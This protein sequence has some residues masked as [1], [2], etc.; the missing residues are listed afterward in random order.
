MG[1]NDAIPWQ[2]TEEKHSHRL[3]RPLPRDKRR[4]SASAKKEE[5]ARLRAVPVTVVPGLG[6]HAHL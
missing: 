6:C 2:C 3:V 4:G 5:E 1:E